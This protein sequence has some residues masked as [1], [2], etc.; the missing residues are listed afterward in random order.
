MSNEISTTL[1]DNINYLK[2]M[3]FNFHFVQNKVQPSVIINL[4]ALRTSGTSKADSLL[5]ANHCHMTKSSMKRVRRCRI[6][7]F[8]QS[9][10]LIL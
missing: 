9:H 7:V 10:Y 1:K 2:A 5:N 6:N 8:V 3:S 4:V